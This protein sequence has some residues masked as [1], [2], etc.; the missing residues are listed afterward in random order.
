MSKIFFFL[1]L[2]IQTFPK[3]NN[4]VSIMKKRLGKETQRQILIVKI[5][6]T[7]IQLALLINNF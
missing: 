7:K 3:S 5:V 2:N 1:S 6:L 4:Y